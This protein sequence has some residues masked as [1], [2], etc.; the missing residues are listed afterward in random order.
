MHISETTNA[1]QENCFERVSPPNDP[2]LH[3]TKRGNIEDN[4]IGREDASN[5]HE[6]NARL[7]CSKSRFAT[8]GLQHHELQV[9]YEKQEDWDQ[10]EPTLEGRAEVH[11][12]VYI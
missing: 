4:E 6:Q 9:D 11:G 3:N 1:C 7:R 8:P 10:R 12:Q 5:H 2:K